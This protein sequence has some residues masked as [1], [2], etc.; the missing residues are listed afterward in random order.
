MIGTWCLESTLFPH[1]Q[2]SKWSHHSLVS[3]YFLGKNTTLFFLKTKK[4]KRGLGK[5][6]GRISRKGT[7]PILLLN[8]QLFEREAPSQSFFLSRKR[9][10]NEISFSETIK[11]LPTDH[12]RLPE[13]IKAFPRDLVIRIVPIWDSPLPFFHPLSQV[14]EIHI[15]LMI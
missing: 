4:K 6:R 3:I 1:T 7:P 12:Q 10:K 14:L 2:S 11:G 9:Q 8:S 13:I 5:K 15:L